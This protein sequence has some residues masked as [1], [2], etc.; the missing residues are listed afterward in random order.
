MITRNGMTSLQA[1]KTLK[2]QTVRVMGKYTGTVKQIHTHCTSG[3]VAEVNVNGRTI[4]ALP[5]ELE[6]LVT[7]QDVLGYTLDA[8]TLIAAATNS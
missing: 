6:V 8:E 7:K 5:S 4:I 3:W 1:R 2:G